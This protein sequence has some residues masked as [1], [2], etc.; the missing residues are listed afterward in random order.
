MTDVQEQAQL[1]QQAEQRLFYHLVA[2]YIQR[3]DAGEKDQHLQGWLSALET[4]AEQA[5]GIPSGDTEAF[6]RRSVNEV[7]RR[8]HPPGRALLAP[9]HPPARRRRAEGMPTIVEAQ[10]LSYFAGGPL[11]R[12][13][14]NAAT[15]LSC[16]HRGWLEPT[17]HAP[18]QRTTAA[19]LA[20][21]EAYCHA[22]DQP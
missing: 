8:H 4:V 13:R 9:V 12:C 21:L 22:Q 11:P 17:D 10:A 15:D 16:Q 20:A 1:A 14:S 3:W 19:G 7:W 2:R 18:Y 5:F 6:V